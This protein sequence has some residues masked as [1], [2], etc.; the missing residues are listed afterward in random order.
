M[1]PEIT[2]SVVQLDEDF[3][4][5]KPAR[6]GGLG[7]GYGGYR[8]RGARESG[9]PTLLPRLPSLFVHMNL[10]RDGG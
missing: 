10:L 1:Q 9:E 3:C 4:L 7:A 8:D 5:S 6:A 2:V